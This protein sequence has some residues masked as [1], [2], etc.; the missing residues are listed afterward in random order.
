MTWNPLKRNYLTTKPTWVPQVISKADDKE[1]DVM[2]HRL[3]HLEEITR[4]LQKEMKKYLE[5]AGALSKAEQKIS[6][7]LSSSP[8]SHQNEKFRTIVDDYHTVTVKGVENVPELSKI[9]Q[10][11]FL[12]PLKKYGSFFSDIDATFHRREQLVQEWKNAAAKVRRLE[13]R[14]RT[15]S[16]VV[17]L[18]RERKT[19][20][21]A[22]EELIVCHKSLLSDVTQFYSRRID[23]LQPSLQALVLAQLDYYG[24]ATRLF[25]LL[26]P[27]PVSGSAAKGSPSSA[28]VIES[29]FQHSVQSKLSQIR[30]LSIVKQ[31]KGSS[32]HT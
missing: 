1:L 7:D 21:T 28:A 6:A 31:S 15:A 9:C 10:Q 14:E 23:Y 22:A 20:E 5:I 2:F 11:G 18:E 13:E 30:A 24:E 4:R 3:Q 12:D 29:E 25:T 8:L 16:N 32:V 26:V 17:K 27:T 19:A